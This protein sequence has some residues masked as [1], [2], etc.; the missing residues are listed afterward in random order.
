M[1]GDKPL[2]VCILFDRRFDITLFRRCVKA[3]CVKFSKRWAG[4]FKEAALVIRKTCNFRWF[5]KICE[6]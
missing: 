5:Q 4:L 1:R 2:S 3:Y 6:E